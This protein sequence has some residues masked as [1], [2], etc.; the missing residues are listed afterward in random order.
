MKCNFAQS[1]TAPDILSKGK[2]YPPTSLDE[3]SAPRGWGSHTFQLANKSDKFVSPTHRPPL[4]TD[5]IPITHF[6]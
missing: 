6:C 2:N 5:K 3:P 4:P 1:L